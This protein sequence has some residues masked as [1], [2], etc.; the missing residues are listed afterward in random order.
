MEI[1]IKKLS[2]KAVIPK[3]SH[4]HDAG[5]D[6]T[7]TSARSLSEF[8]EYGTDL[9]IDI[10]PGFVGLIYPRSSISN[11]GMRLCNSVGVIDS[12]YSGEIKIRMEYGTN[13][14]LVG[15]RIAQLVIMPR[16]SV[17]FVEVEELD[18]TE[19]SSGGFGSTGA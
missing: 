9:A 17:S 5:M 6:I 1:K 13:N 18:D 3:Y 14:Y 7:A 15:D 16:P 12:G 4:Q 2:N 11:T 10:P 19:R 8:V